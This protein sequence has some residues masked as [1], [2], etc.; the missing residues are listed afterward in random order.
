MGLIRES[1]TEKEL[2]LTTTGQGLW[3]AHLEAAG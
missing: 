3:A 2:K 1:A